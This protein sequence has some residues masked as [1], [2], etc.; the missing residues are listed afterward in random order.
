MP[1][2]ARD[3]LDLSADQ[4]DFIA[5]AQ[6]FALNEIRPRAR[7][8]DDAQ[9]ESP[10]D[11][12]TKAAK[13]GLASFMIPAEYGGGGLT[14]MVTQLL[15]QEQLCYGDI[16][17]GNFVTSSGFFADPI[18]ELGT[19]EQKDR[20]LRPL[21]T[22]A[23]PVTALATTEPDYGSD[24]AGIQTRAVRDGDHYVL[25]GQKTWISN[26]PYAQRF[27]IFATVDPALR[28]RGV[29]AFVV[30]RDTPGLTV[31]KPMR[32]MGQR[33]I[34]NAELFLDD[35]RVPVADRLGEEGQGFFG[36]MRTF[37]ASR[38]LIGA[39]CAGLSRAALDYATDYAKNRRQFGKPIIEHQAVAFRL[40]DMAVRTDTAH[41]TAVRA[42]QLFD[43]GERVTTEAAMAKLVG[44][45]NAMANT[46]G[47]VQ[48]LG[49][50]GYSQEFLVEKWM[51]DAKLEEI[52]EG[53]SDIQ[54]LIISRALAS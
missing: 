50:W 42:A 27:V 43:R 52:E 12:W 47:A 36:L 45:E 8:V 39:S 3:A 18:L 44:S 24:A 48:T 1:L 14:D 7:E 6:D 13:I 4:R 51:R 25:S 46:W 54:R 2:I 19:E 5:L 29:T 15:V 26:A 30:E 20:W 16:G 40:A 35:V 28:S 33:G 9:T 37:D 49:G 41:L 53:T 22:D 10:L 21:T 17:I 32:K 11:L 31:G 38:I 23:P 34:V